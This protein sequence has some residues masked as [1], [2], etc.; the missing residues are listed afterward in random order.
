VEY[1][2]YLG[3]DFVGRLLVFGSQRD[4]Q[5]DKGQLDGFCELVI[6]EDALAFN[7]TANE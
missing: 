3:T 5:V 2:I 7:Q 6:C 1:V 4:A